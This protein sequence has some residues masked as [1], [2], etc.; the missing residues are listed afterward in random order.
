MLPETVSRCPLGA[1]ISH[2]VTLRIIDS[3]TSYHLG[4]LTLPMW[5][6]MTLAGQLVPESITSP[7][8]IRR[9]I[10]V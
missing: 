10:R 1:C 4:S 5:E 2:D 9:R 7:L 3:Y 6:G 8:G